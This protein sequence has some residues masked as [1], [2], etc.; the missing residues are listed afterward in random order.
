MK[1]IWQGFN[2]LTFKSAIW[3]LESGKEATVHF[4]ILNPWTHPHKYQNLVV[5]YWDFEN[6]YTHVH[7][8]VCT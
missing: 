2:H 1:Y 4:L 6:I 7:K 3:K 5:Y 8:E